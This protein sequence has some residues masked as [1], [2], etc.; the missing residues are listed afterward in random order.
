MY[1][2]KIRPIIKL[3]GILLMIES[4]FMISCVPYSIYYGSQDL[5]PILISAAITFGTG[6]IL[7]FARR[8][9]DQHDLGKREGYLI[10]V[11][12]WVIISFFG[13]LPFY[14]S[15]A[16]PSFTD[17]Y[18]ETMSGF[19]T[20]GASILRDI[21]IVP[22][23]LLFWRSLTH[24]IGGMGII[25]LSIA[26]LPFLGFGG[27]S[28][29]WAEV[30]GPEKEKLHPRIAVTAR[31]LWG[32]YAALTLAMVIMLMLGGMNLFESLCHAFGALSSGGFSPKNT[33]LAGYSPY[34]Q[35]VA[36]LFMFLA[37]T[38]FTLHYLLIRGSVKKAL[39]GQEFRSYLLVLLIPAAII[40]IA[41]FFERGYGIE[42]A[43]RSALF[44]VVSIVTCTGFANED[45]MLWP[46]FAW[47]IIFLLM[48]S[49]GMAGST[50]GGIKIVR[51]LLL[52]KNLGMV[53][54]KLL[55]KSAVVPVR[56][57]N[58]T[59]NPLIIHNVLAIFFLYIITFGFGSLLLTATGLDVVSSMGSVVT[60][61]GGIGPGLATTGPVA[62]YAHLTDFAKWVLSFMM[63][64]GRLELFT[65][66]IIFHPAFW[67]R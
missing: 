28:L 36:I 20:T 1:P 64:L 37:G 55:H 56:L 40:A 65:L 17:A 59:V 29:F 60:C 61:M 50:S 7:W 14:L 49:G 53:L 5:L 54:K 3:I 46:F 63:L 30:P 48:F 10:V 33:S 8:K 34:I 43:W 38:N 47:F 62:N 12:T 58:K 23:G 31:R 67:K 24:W 11:L 6:G 22:K 52:F 16:I 35:Y 19:S 2:F 27:M 51:H 26:I 32:I 44:N 15:H 66:F 25:V 42:Q 39:S 41:L 4:L 9:Y 21:E 13:A 57:D 18:F 45:Y